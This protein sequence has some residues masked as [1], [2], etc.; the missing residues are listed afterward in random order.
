MVSYIAVFLLK[1]VAYMFLS[2]TQHVQALARNE[3]TYTRHLSLFGGNLSW[4]LYP[5][6]RMICNEIIPRWSK[7]SARG[8]SCQTTI[9]P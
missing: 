8:S 9:S 2:N 6:R 3:P 7:G 4:R 1:N 5:T